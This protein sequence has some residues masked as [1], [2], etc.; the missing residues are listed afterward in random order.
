MATP[1]LSDAVPQRHALCSV[2]ALWRVAESVPFA[3][4]E[5]YDADGSYG[6]LSAECA[7]FAD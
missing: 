3:R 4:P 7:F 1:G 5:R 2:C 6:A